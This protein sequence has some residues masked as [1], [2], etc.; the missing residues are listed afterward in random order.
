LC[1]SQQVAHL[2]DKEGS[3]IG[4]LVINWRILIMI[5]KILFKALGTASAGALA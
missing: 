5:V 2:R 4:A 1:D 3:A